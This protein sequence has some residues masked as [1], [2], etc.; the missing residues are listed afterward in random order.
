M[1]VCLRVSVFSVI[2]S[3]RRCLCLCVC[4]CVRVC[5]CACTCVC[6]CC[7]HMQLMR[8]SKGKVRVYLCVGVCKERG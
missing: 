3:V 2:V 1:L 4:M 8:I 5:V 7:V 6:A